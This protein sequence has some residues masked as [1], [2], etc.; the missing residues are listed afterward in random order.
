MTGGSITRWQTSESGALFP[1]A[2]GRGADCSGWWA[3]CRAGS[4]CDDA[5][6][7]GCWAEGWR[8]AHGPPS[9]E[10]LLLGK[11]L[12]HRQSAGASVLPPPRAPP[13]SDLDP[14]L[15]GHEGPRQAG[16]KVPSPVGS[17]STQGGCAGHVPRQ[18][19][20]CVLGG[21]ALTAPR[22]WLS[23]PSISCCLCC[24]PAASVSAQ[25]VPL[26]PQV[27]GVR[28]AGGNAVS[29]V[30]VKEGGTGTASSSP[31]ET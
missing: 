13:S 9:P 2:V 19:A 29:E 18:P 21:P 4:S 22:P 16:A 7:R 15:A 10:A 12:P 8:P 23:P 27:H 24:A 11:A 26:T 3:H 6:Q 5:P 25:P 20:S 30:A 1:T 28:G 17:D 14:S 31:T